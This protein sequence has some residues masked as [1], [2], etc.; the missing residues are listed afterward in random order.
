M[1]SP[2][3]TLFSLISH[4]KNV[5]LATLY[6]LLPVVLISVSYSPQAGDLGINKLFVGEAAPLIPG[7]LRHP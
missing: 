1:P 3:N 7:L 6:C 5:S 4:N 2:E